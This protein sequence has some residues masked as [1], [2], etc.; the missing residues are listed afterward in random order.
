MSVVGKLREAY[1]NVVAIFKGVKNKEDKEEHELVLA[2]E[3]IRNNFYN[4]LS[5]FGKYF[6][7]ALE[8]EHVYNALGEKDISLYKKDLKF[9][10]ELRASVKLR[11]SDT[12]DHK[13]YE[14]KM[15]NL[16]DTYIAAEDVI[17]I[18]APVDV[19][20]EEE[21]E[22]E[23]MRLG[24]PRAKADAIRT[25]IT[26]S[27]NQKWDENPAY[28]KKFSERIEEIINEYK[29]KRISDADYLKRMR[30][31]MQNF[32]K[33]Y[34]G[35]VYP[36]KIKHNVNAQALYGVVKE[37]LEDESLYS[38]GNDAVI[39][40]QNIYNYEN[41]LA[42]IATDINL[43]IEKHWKVDWHDNSDVHNM[44]SSDIN[45]LLYLA[46]KKHFSNLSFSQIDKII[47]NIKT[48]ALRRY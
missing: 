18:T 7:I 12:I 17:Q 6:G 25:R 11:Y 36:E 16:M 4:H 47:E 43:I 26:K 37:I 34:S 40:T 14:S 19:L 46:K 1:S 44:I 23:L 9:Y 13:E 5:Q 38:S 28:Y 35:T 39:E 15:R 45:D 30:E 20:N 31:V 22:D 27:I 3:E 33:G 2:D 29:E 32:R 10:Q 48:I 42:D 8:S 24:T 21:L 41:I